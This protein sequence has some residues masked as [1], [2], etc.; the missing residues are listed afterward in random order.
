MRQA[1]D[2]IYEWSIPRVYGSTPTVFGAPLAQTTEELERADVAFLGIPW[3]APRSDNRFGT[4]VANFDGTN[5][6]PD[7]FR[8]NSLKYGPYLPEFDLDIFSSLSLVDAGNVVVSEANTD[9]SLENV[10]EFV[11]R[12][13]SAGTIPFTLG[14]NSGPGSYSVVCGIADAIGESVRVLHLDAHS[15]CRPID[16]NEDTATNPAWG[17]TWVWRLLQSDSARGTEYFHFGLRG[18]RNHAD[19]FNWLSR[20]GV[21][22][23]N[24]VTYKEIRHARKTNSTSEWI[25]SFARNVVGTEG[26]IWIGIDVDVLNLGSN[27]DWGDEPMGPSATEVAELLWQ[28]GKAAGKERLAG[29]SIMAMPFDA[30]SLHSI[31]MYLVLYLFAGVIGGEL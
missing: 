10:R 23:E 26:K 27:P 13:V 2:P 28:V 12:I 9:K 17:G 4:S 20:A 31:C 14:G 6:T 3:S 18:P 21:P 19:T 30:Q 1:I 11:K 25:E 5:L 24:V 15:D 8:I 16:Q 29:I 22:R 7:K